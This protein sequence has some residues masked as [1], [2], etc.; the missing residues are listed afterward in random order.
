M[1]AIIRRFEKRAERELRAQKSR[2]VRVET[3]APPSN[4]NGSHPA[5]PLEDPRGS[6]P[7]LGLRQYW[8]PALPDRKIRRKPLYWNM[9]GDDLVFF[10]DKQ[11]EV[12]AVSDICPHRGASMSE[13]NCFYKGFL[14]CPYHGATFDGKGEC[15]AFIPEGPDS[16]MVGNLKVRAY[17]TRTLHGWVFVW[18]GEG[19]PV[20]MTGPAAFVYQGKISL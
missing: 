8:Y 17:P 3:Q 10:R 19:E 11:G 14:S 20:W 15:V 7:P 16:K 2:G 12:A 1:G 9:L 5:L 13:G 4:G 18:M 6:I